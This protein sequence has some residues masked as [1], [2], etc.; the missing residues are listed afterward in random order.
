MLSKREQF[1]SLWIKATDRLPNPELHKHI[2][3]Y[4]EHS[5]LINNPFSFVVKDI[6]KYMNGFW[7]GTIQR[8]KNTICALEIT[9]WM[10]I[11]P[12]GEKIE[13]DDVKKSYA[14]EE[15]P[16]SRRVS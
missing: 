5:G 2:L 13:H 6:V 11:Y 15:V 12:V 8:P 10:P 7:A 9:H 3:T 1:E 4:N 16:R 14:Y